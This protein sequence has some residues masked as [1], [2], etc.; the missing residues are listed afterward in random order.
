MVHLNNSIPEISS[1]GFW[2]NIKS[3]VYCS[4][5]HDAL[6]LKKILGYGLN[7]TL[8]HDT[9]GITNY[10]YDWILQLCLVYKAIISLFSFTNLSLK[11]I[12]S[13]LGYQPPPSFLQIPQLNLQTVQAPSLSGNFPLYI[14]VFRESHSK[15]RIFQWTPITL[16]LFILHS[17]PS[18]KSN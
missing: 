16:K 13:K 1:G 6:Y 4:F 3:A 10:G 8:L 2:R 7:W 14:L 12:S 15:N 5:S 18:F 9:I 11:T 17:I